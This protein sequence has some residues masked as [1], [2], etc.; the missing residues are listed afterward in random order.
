M[1]LPAKPNPKTDPAYD[2]P[3]DDPAHQI[4]GGRV[5]FIDEEPNK[6]S[7]L[8]TNSGEWIEFEVPETE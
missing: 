7:V 5:D 8:G 3:E 4:P 1:A 6:V 2:R